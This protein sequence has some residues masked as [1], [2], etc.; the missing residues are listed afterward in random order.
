M[1]YHIKGDGKMF[2]KQLRRNIES[3]DVQIGVLTKELEGLK[4]DTKYDA[5]MR[6]LSDFGELRS[7]LTMKNE[8]DG[9]KSDVIVELDKQIEDL[10]QI[11]GELESDEIYVQKVK[12]L[13]D[14]TK[15][16]CQLAEAKA[17]ESNISTYM[18]AII[19]G[20]VGIALTLIVLN[21]EKEDIIT[22]K[23]A[24]GIVTR[25]FRGF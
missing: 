7:K 22:S 9:T 4:K 17:R 14:L 3:L 13:E 18:P 19:S 23:N 16:R 11:I 15:V 2:N 5:K 25:M 6:M 8:K 20:T 21:Y 1:G 24:F 10:T 12:K